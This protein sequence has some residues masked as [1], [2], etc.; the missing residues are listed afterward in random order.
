MKYPLVTVVWDDACSSG[1]WQSIAE[2]TG[3]PKRCNTTGYLLKKT[4][5]SVVVSHTVSAD[6][7]TC[8]ELTIPTQMVKVVKRL[9]K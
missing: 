4:K 5:E 3:T 9:R 8:C 6:G 7:D 2:L 1:R